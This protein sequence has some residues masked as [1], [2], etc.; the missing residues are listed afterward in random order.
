MYTYIRIIYYYYLQVI[1][2]NENRGADE[3]IF[4]LR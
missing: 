2:K 4:N 1:F 3:P